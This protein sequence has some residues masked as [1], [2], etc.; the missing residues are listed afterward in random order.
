M[1]RVIDVNRQVIRNP[2]FKIDH[3]SSQ[4]VPAIQLPVI[5]AVPGDENTCYVD[6]TT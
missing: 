1:K 3:E 6:L 5:Q 2:V 4:Q